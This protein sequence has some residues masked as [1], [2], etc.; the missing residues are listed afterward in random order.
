MGRQ[1][2]I[3]WNIIFFL[4][5][6]VAY[7]GDGT[8]SNADLADNASV[9]LSK[10]ELIQNNSVVGNASGGVT[11]P[12]QLNSAQLTSIL[13]AFTG[14]SG[15]G[16]VKGAVPAPSAGDAGLGKF[17][18]AGG[19]WSV[20]STG[21]ESPLTTKGDLY[22][23][24][25]ANDRLPVG[26]DTYVLTADSVQP[27]GVKWAAP[28]ASVQSV[29]VADVKSSGTQGGDFN[30]GAWRTRDLNTLTNPNSY[31]WVSLSSNQVTLSAGTYLIQA[32]APAEYVE[33]HQARLQNITDGTTDL[34]GSSM[35]NN[36]TGSSVMNDSVIV[37]I[38]TIAGTK[39]FEIQHQCQTGRNNTGFGIPTGTS[40]TVT[41][42]VYTTMVITKL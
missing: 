20:P 24:G 8:I 17:L 26:I 1:F 40:F 25:A 11:N 32:R 7:A 31:S 39:T 36:N 42:E 12:Q 15:S 28:S 27:L 9:A 22:V 18:H 23:Y 38:I 41:N 16:G 6:A 19:G 4:A 33:R 34:S 29:T 30:N 10:L 2:L 37:G 3:I 35:F 14:D 5:T 21:V 13:D